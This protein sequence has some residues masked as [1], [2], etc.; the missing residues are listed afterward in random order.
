MVD[1]PTASIN[2][3]PPE[4]GPI[5]T[6][7]RAFRSVTTRLETDRPLSK[8]WQDVI[9]ATPALHERELS[10]WE[11]L[12]GAL[13]LALA[14]RG[15]S[16]L[17][18]TLATRTGMAALAHVTLSWLEQEQPRSAERLDQTE[19]ALKD[20]LSQGFEVSPVPIPRET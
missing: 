1:A 2:A 7:F 11:A 20:L 13:A 15:V 3:A 12:A 17:H 4:T 10:K 5:D 16:A 9:S 8:P 14:T 19:Q 18:A 6:L